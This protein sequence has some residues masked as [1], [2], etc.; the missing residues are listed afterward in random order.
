VC[1]CCL[2]SFH[3]NDKIVF[4]FIALSLPLS[5]IENHYNHQ[6]DDE[7]QGME[8]LRGII[9]KLGGWPLLSM[10]HDDITWNDSEWSLEG[11]VEAIRKLIRSDK[12]F[13]IA[14]FI[15]HIQHANSVRNALNSICSADKCFSSFSEQRPTTQS[16]SSVRE[17]YRQYI[18]QTVSMLGSNPIEMREI[19]DLLSFEYKLNEVCTTEQSGEKKMKQKEEENQAFQCGS[20]IFVKEKFIFL[21]E[22]SHVLCQDNF[23]QVIVELQ[24]SL[25]HSKTVHEK[26]IFFS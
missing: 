23:I 26:K 25:K 19:D 4:F 17:A 21:R 3:E 16:Y 2:S 18:T 15:I 8:E 10:N 13:D 11:T 7:D 6:V 14:S 9:E 24:F 20:A 1:V 22:R 5:L 12:I